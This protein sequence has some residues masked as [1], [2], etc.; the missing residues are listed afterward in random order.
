L[1]KRFFAVNIFVEFSGTSEDLVSGIS[2]GFTT[3]GSGLTVGELEGVGIADAVGVGEAVGV[4]DALGVG[5]GITFPEFHV[6]M[7][8]PLLFP[9][10][11]V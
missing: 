11:H 4:C 9:L 7:V 5:V 1:P 6:R 8:F 3:I 2:T 10:M